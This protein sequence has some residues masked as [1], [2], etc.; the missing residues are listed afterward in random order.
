MGHGV[1]TG[2]RQ[3][4]LPAGQ[5]HPV[6]VPCG[7][8]PQPAFGE[9]LEAQLVMLVHQTIPGRPFVQSGGAARS[10]RARFE[11]ATC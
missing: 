3:S 11:Q 10:C 9:L 5:R 6:A 4:A 8:I 2:P 1:C 7:D